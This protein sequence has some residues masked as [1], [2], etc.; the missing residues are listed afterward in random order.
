MSS[1]VDTSLSGVHP[2]PVRPKRK[3]EGSALLDDFP[4]P[5]F[6]CGKL[7]CALR[8]AEELLDIPTPR[9]FKD[10]CLECEGFG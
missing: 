5:P 4:R 8:D 9:D 7:L 3:F 10:I 1:R 6:L 2:S